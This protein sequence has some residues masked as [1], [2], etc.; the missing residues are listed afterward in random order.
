[1]CSELSNWIAFKSFQNYVFDFA[2]ELLT[3]YLLMETSQEDATNTHA[4]DDVDGK[5]IV[6][7]RYYLILFNRQQ[8]SL[9]EQLIEMKRVR[10]ELQCSKAYVTR[11]G[12]MKWRSRSLRVSSWAGQQAFPCESCDAIWSL[13]I[14]CTFFKA[15]THLLK[16]IMPCVS[17]LCT[18]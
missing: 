15:A 10:W 14:V 17:S 4:I 3:D 13:Q 9:F 5:K 18:R 6:N 16:N 11:L 7:H 1:M 2:R 12:M 8:C